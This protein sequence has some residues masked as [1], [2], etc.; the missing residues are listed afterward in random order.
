MKKCPYCAEEI[1]DEAIKC[2]H[3]KEAL[4]KNTIAD[5]KQAKQIKKSEFAGT[6]MW[7]QLVGLFLC[8]TGVGIIIGIPLII[9]GSGK[10]TVYK[11]SNCMNKIEKNAKVCPTC[12]SSIH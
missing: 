11:C 4:E 1:Q 6:G 8:F 12:K 10:A 3:C 7:Y 5:T 2:K 9:V